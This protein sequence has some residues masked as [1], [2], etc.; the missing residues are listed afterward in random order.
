MT[1]RELITL[2]GG[3]AAWPLAARAQP[4]QP[5]IGFLSPN[6][7]SA[8]LV[9]AFRQGLKEVGFVEGQN[10]AIEYRS[11]EGRYD[12]L[13]EL[14]AD[15]VRRQVSVIAVP[16]NAIAALAAMAATKT[17]PIVFGVSEDPVRLG[18]VASLSHPGGNA[19]GVN[20]FLAEIGAK[21]LGLLRELLPAA[22]RVAILVNPLNVGSASAARRELEPAARALG[23]QI[24]FYEASSSREIDAS[25]AGLVRAQPDALFVAPD[26]LFVSRRVQLTALA[27]RHLL[28]VT[29]P[30]RDSVEAGGLMSYGTNVADMYRQVG[31]YAGRI[32]KGAKP[33]DLPVVQASKFE[34]VINLQAARLL[35][36]DVP[37][38]LLAR[39]DEVIE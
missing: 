23:L 25:F 11:A 36:I 12:Q 29:Y 37:S 38:M 16:G 5:M 22:G 3:A 9:A 6:T 15:L 20:F 17:I 30:E 33:A 19:T 21:R 14:A 7:F 31:G 18:L 34:L 13:P 28:P 32:L 35:G 4:A 2:L 26:T 1:H 10:V 39:A 24:Q 27:A 8:P